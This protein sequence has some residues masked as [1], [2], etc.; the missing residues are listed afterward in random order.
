MFCKNQQENTGVG[1]FL[2]IKPQ[3]EALRLYSKETLA[4]IKGVFK[5]HLNIYD[6]AFMQKYR[7]GS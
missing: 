3:P 4:H 7:R 5:T 1:A 6:G 2:Q